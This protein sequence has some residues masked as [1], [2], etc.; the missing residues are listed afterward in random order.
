[1]TFQMTNVLLVPI[2]NWRDFIHRFL[3]SHPD[4]S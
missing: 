2:E 3:F 1:V 4:G